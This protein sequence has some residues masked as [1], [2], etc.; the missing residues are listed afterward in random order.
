[1]PE[2]NQESLKDKTAKAASQ[3][4]A[5]HIIFPYQA[6]KQMGEM[7]KAIFKADNNYKRILSWDKTAAQKGG[8]IAE[9]FHAETF[10]LDAIL[11]GKSSRAI[12]DRYSEWQ[13]QGYR[14]NDVPDVVIVKDGQ[15]VSEAQL[16]YYASAEASATKVSEVK[17]EVMDELVVPKGQVKKAKDYASPE[18]A[19]RIK[20]QITNEDVSSTPLTK[21]EADKM[22]GGDLSKRTETTGRLKTQSTLRQM[23]RAATGAAAMSAIVCGSIN[24]VSYIQKVQAGEISQDEAVAKILVET[25]TSAA[26]SALKAAANTGV[27]SLITRY[28]EKAV[29]ENLAKQSAKTLLKSNAVTVGVVC[30]VDAVKDLVALGLGKI[31]K[32]EF[33]ER[34]GKGL[35][36]TSAGVWGGSLGAAG[37]NAGFCLL[38]GATSVPFLVPLLGGLAGGLIAGLAMNLAI[39]NGIERPFREVVAN[40]AA[41][42]N[43]ALE[44]KSVA[45]KMYSG[46]IIFN[47]IWE[48]EADQE[49]AI[50]QEFGE[51]DAAG[52]EALHNIIK[53]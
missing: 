38:L 41:M 11:K 44:V 36:N 9:E 26:D 18:A 31:S 21:P 37:A 53:I 51:I 33:Y 10:N 20:D 48:M 43:T 17:Y 40:M 23:G 27:Q 42:Q 47:R 2:N 8:S 25:A 12:T 16:K 22:G 50:A 19:P 29:V 34:Q 30:A 5:G 1:M 52:R 13:K 6:K 46:Q 3:A 35:L 24:I 32:D 45:E 7:M 4:A 49:S 28:G 39:E 15:V 14:P